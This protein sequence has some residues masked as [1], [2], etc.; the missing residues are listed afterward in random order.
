MAGAYECWLLAPLRRDGVTF[1]FLAAACSD[2]SRH[3]ER[4]LILRQL[5]EETAM[6]VENARLF[7]Q[8]RELSADEERRRLARELHDGVA[9]AL[10]HVRL[11]LEFLARHAT[12]SDVRGDAARLARVVDRALG[13]VRSTIHGLRAAAP[14]EGLAAALR[15]YLRDLQRLGGP[16]ILFN[17]G[18]VS[19]YPPEVEAEVFRIAQEAVSNALRHA[20]ASRIAVSLGIAPEGL[21]L[22]VEDDGVGLRPDA[23]S[24]SG[25]G[26]RAMRERA[27]RLGARLTLVRGP[28]G[29]TR[30][31]LLVDTGPAAEPLAHLLRLR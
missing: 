26:L 2:H 19:G 16:E 18:V 30:V 17:A 6:A 4:R 22:S 14:G 15:A 8:V 7:S 20:R 25:L 3:E 23:T 9:Q 28:S 24:G 10:T 1:G 27:Q 29:G 11:E 31:D 12:A 21:R 5:A 13:D